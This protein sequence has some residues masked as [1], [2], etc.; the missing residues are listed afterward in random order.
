MSR[1]FTIGVM[2]TG[3]GAAIAI[4]GLIIHKIMNKGIQDNFD[5]GDSKNMSIEM[6]VNQAI[7]NSRKNKFK[8]QSEIRRLTAWCND[9][10]FS[11]YHAEYEKAGAF[12]NKEEL[13]DKYDEISE[14]YGQGISFETSDKCR[15]VVNDYQLK[16]DG[17]KERI[18]V[19]EQKEKEYSDLKD[20]LKQ[21]KQQ[22]KLM[23]KLESHEAE[24]QS[25]LAS[26]SEMEQLTMGDIAREVTEKEEYYKQ[27]EQLDFKYNR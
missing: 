26:D 11:T 3:A 13:L 1:S 22:E 24:V 9:A 16:I 6:K 14:K 5:G 7:S 2:A 25:M 4:I 23:K 15:S 18:N 12:Y 19:F 17:Y 27:L 21:I 20:K 10:I 8:A